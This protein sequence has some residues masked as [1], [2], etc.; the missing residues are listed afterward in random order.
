MKIKL[1]LLALLASATLNA[2]DLDTLTNLTGKIES[3]HNCLAVGDSGLAI[4]EFQF[5]ADAWEQTSTF[6]KTLGKKVYGYDKAT[7]KVI[8]TDYCKDYLQWIAN[9]L[10]ARLGREPLNW[11]IYASFNRGVGAFAKV[12]YSFDRLPSWTKR[13]CTMIAQ[14]TGEKI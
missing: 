5:H 11:E 6:R 10:Q 4:G 3:S 12:G 2:Y 7:D 8:A 1:T 9:R 14:E 13:S